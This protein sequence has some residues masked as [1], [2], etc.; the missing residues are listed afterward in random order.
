MRT[1]FR[2]S[3]VMASGQTYTE[4]RAAFQAE[5]HI[6]DRL[7]EFVVPLLRD[8][9]KRVGIAGD[10][11]GRSKE[12]ESFA[13]KAV[14]G[15]Y[16]EPLRQIKD[17]AGARITLVYGDDVLKATD[18]VRARLHVLNCESKLDALAFNEFGYL[19]VHCD[20]QLKA[21]DAVGPNADLAGHHIEVQIRT[22]VQSAWAEVSHAQLYKPPAGVP[23]ALKRRI[24]RLVALVELFD[25]E[26][27]G[28]LEES[29]KTPGFR[30]AVALNPLASQLL[31]RF[32][33]RISPDRGLSL[34]MAAA[35]VPL[36]DETP[37]DLFPAILAPWINANEDA[38]RVHFD[39]A[40]ALPSNPLSTQPEVFLILERLVNDQAR[41]RD[42]WPVSIPSV[43][44]DQLADGWGYGHA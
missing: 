17:K 6:Y 23:D 14:L 26:V 22:M 29:T 12:P 1:S 24:H 2:A 7:V 8:D 21:V 34:T 31:E 11:K 15:S 25:A 32:D 10:V 28:F 44:Y 13:R 35:I 38:L 20:T 18:V 19:G 9:L 42:A 41:L 16:K 39:E 33:V 43:W 36:Y 37:V 30:E 4:I 40:A 27:S 3:I 5:R